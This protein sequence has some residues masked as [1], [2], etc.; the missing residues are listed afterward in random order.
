M[1]GRRL[2]LELHWLVVQPM[3][4][5][6]RE[7]YSL[8][9]NYCYAAACWCPLVVDDIFLRYVLTSGVA[10][11]TLCPIVVVTVC[12]VAAGTAELLHRA[13]GGRVQQR[14]EGPHAQG[15]WAN[16]SFGSRFTG[17]PG[18]QFGANVRLL[19]R[20]WVSSVNTCIA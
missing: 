1:P 13:L 16:K 2:S 6:G 20:S 15:A 8:V 3:C 14:G 4:D 17:M 19:S 18:Y 11:E 9:S 5:K 12:F 10:T 7:P